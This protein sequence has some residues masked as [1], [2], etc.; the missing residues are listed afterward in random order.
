[1]GIQCRIGQILLFTID[2]ITVSYLLSDFRYLLT[3]SSCSFR[4][5]QKVRV[6]VF[7]TNTLLE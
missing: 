6:L 3:E 1:M 7:K 2:I 4:L 5:F